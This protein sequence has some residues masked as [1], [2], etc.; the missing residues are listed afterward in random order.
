AKPRPKD[1]KKEPCV[2]L[3]AVPPHKRNAK[4]WTNWFAEG[5]EQLAERDP[6][7]VA[8][9]AAM[10][11]GTGL[12]Q[13]A[14]R[15]PDR[16]FD[17][18]IAEQHCVAFASGLAEA[19]RRPIA[20]I[21]STFLQRAYDQ[22]FQEVAIQNLPV[23]FAMDRAG[24]VG[25]DGMT[26]NGLFDIAYLRTLPNLVLMAPKDGPELWS[27][28]EFAIAHDGPVGIRYARGG[29]PGPGDLPGFS[30]E[31]ARIA[32]GRMEVIRSGPDG[33][34][35]AYGHMVQTALDAAQMLAARGIEI[36]VVNARFAKPLDEA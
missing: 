33:A 10:P 30:G 8:L 26:H 18:G 23:V 24:I 21:Y 16:F 13:F 25:E 11:D 36:E 31:S 3:P 1:E 5:V 32:L 2:V 29:A 22:V 17:T 9:T 7:V 34:I 28:L 19:G 35:L 12:M 4:A 6:R 20:A 27:M 14:E 15:F